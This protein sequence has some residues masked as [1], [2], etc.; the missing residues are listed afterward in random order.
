MIPTEGAAEQAAVIRASLEMA[1][2][3]AE[4]LART[5]GV[6]GASLYSWRTGRRS[7]RP[8]ARQRLVQAL[9]AQARALLRLA[10][11]LAQG[12]GVRS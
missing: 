2:P 6:S 7:P 4:Q 1:C 9:R 10:D 12:S 5:I 11:Q 8:E 3:T